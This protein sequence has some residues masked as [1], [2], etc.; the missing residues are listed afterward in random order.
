MVTENL[1]PRGT[2]SPLHVHHY[3][4]DE[5]FYVIEGEPSLYGSA[6]TSSPP[7]RG[8]SVYGPAGRACTHSWSAPSRLRYLLVTE[9]AGFDSFIRAVGRNRL[10][11]LEIPP[12]PTAPPDM[13][14]IMQPSPRSPGWR[15]SQGLP[16][17][18]PGGPAQPGRISLVQADSSPYYREDLALV[19]D[20]GFGFHA[21]ACA[22][23]VLA[24]LGAR[25]LR[26]R[27][28]SRAGLWQWSADPRAG[29]RWTPRDRHGCLPGDAEARRGASRP[30]RARA[31]PADFFPT[32]RFPPP[33]RWWWRSDTRSTTFQ[34]PTDR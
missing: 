10:P 25:L 26:R 17:S 23:G 9:P 18:R 32:I 28:R 5:W 6:A 15:I 34:T 1:G 31:S 33:T 30:A 22:P 7:R 11:R 4:E 12:A 8:A 13:E 16:G 14:R 3:R 20:R 29:C 24:F 19:H 2:G 21:A 27:P